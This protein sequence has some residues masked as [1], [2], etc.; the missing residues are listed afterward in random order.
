MDLV[1]LLLER[2]GNV[3]VSDGLGYCRVYMTIM[4]LYVHTRIT[5]FVFRGGWVRSLYVPHCVRVC[6]CVFCVCVCVCSRVGTSVPACVCVYCV[7]VWQLGCLLASACVLVQVRT[8]KGATPFFLA[9]RE[10]HLDISLMLYNKGADTEVPDS[11]S[12]TPLL[13]SFRNGHV[14]VVE[15]LLKYVKAFP[16]DDDC[17]VSKI[18]ACVCAR[19]CVRG[20]GG[21]GVGV[22]V[23]GGG[24][25]ACVCVCERGGGVNFTE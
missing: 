23:G 8:K 22:C 12:V 2:G 19:V 25:N 3:D 24:Q 11:R 15:W 14:N 6:V 18:H 4:T 17:S 5:R 20:G 7:H 16:S 21:G 9:C 10:G 13:A 1:K